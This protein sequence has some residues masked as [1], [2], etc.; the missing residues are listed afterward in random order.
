[1]LPLSDGVIQA[2]WVT[3]RQEMGRSTG[4]SGCVGA[5][6]CRSVDGK[7]GYRLSGARG[8]MQ[9]VRYWRERAEPTLQQVQGSL[10]LPLDS[11][12]G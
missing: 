7:G 2:G 6:A 5:Q 9:I 10:A 12:H 8:S 11:E 4:W 1:M 3:E